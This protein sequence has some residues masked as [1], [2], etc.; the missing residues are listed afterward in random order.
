MSQALAALGEVCVARSSLVDP[1]E[2][3]FQK[4]PH[5]APDNIERGT[6]WLLPYRT[7]LEAGVTSGKYRFESGDVLYSKIRPNLNKV[8]QVDFPGLCSADM[9]ALDVDRSRAMPSYV[10]HLLRSD[11]FLSYATSLSNRAN[12][13][14]LNR[15]Q[16]M[17]FQF[18]L[19]PLDEQRRIAAILDRADA[20]RAKRRQALAHLDHLTQSFFQHMFASGVWPA[21]KLGEVA[22]TTSGGTPA[23]GNPK[24]YGGDIPWVK[25]GELNSGLVS[26]AEESITELGL[27]SS[28]AKVLPAGTVLLAMYGATAGVVGQLGIE[29]ATNQAVCAITPGPLLEDTYLIAMLRSLT[30]T[31]LS[32]T[33]GGAQP[34]LSQGTIRSLDLFVPPLDLQRE[35]A[36]RIDSCNAHQANLKRAG[37]SNDVLFESIQSRAFRGDL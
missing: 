35:F 31:L 36:A 15:G 1:R 25:S 21:A 11:A 14:K 18:R 26:D 29:A 30:S 24:F 8:M 13:P 17:N 27:A 22:S 19:P 23:R 34:N 20:L 28:S 12:I 3:E 32:R 9:Y 5:I 10:V 6:G 37:V 7:V 2:T 4:L 33:A 16:L